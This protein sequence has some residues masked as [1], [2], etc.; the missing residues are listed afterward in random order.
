MPF[1]QL[2]GVPFRQLTDV[3]FRQLT[4]VPLVYP[5]VNSLVYP[6]VNLLVY[7]SVKNGVPFRQD[8]KFLSLDFEATTL[9][10]VVFVSAFCIVFNDLLSYIIYHYI[11]LLLS[12]PIILLLNNFLTLSLYHCTQLNF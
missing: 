10:I 3:P 5:S 7:P 12:S 8:Y 6:S 2:T 1:R 11:T 4:G 9:Y